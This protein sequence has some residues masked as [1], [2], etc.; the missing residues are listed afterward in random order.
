M[1]IVLQDEPGLFVFP[2]I[3][4]AHRSIE[5]YDAASIVRAAFDD[6]AIPYRVEWVRP[7]RRRKRFFGLLSFT[8]PGEYRFIAAGPPD[9]DA[10]AKLL[11][12]HPEFTNPPEA[13]ADLSRL[14]S[15][16]RHA[17]S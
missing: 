3:E 11:A 8:D 10:L 4:E 12:E 6:R 17:S 1:L 7:Q 16:L 13:K 15:T 14:L 2:T 9:P 5:V